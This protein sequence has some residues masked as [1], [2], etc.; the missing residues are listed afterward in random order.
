MKP[1]F[2]RAIAR[3]GALVLSTVGAGGAL[4]TT[5][6]HFSPEGEALR[7]NQVS[8]NFDAPVLALG[9]LTGPAPLTFRCDHGVK[10]TPRWVDT[11]TW[12]LDFSAALPAGIRCEFK[13]VAGFKDVA[14]KPVTM[15]KSYRFHTGGPWAVNVFAGYDS[16]RIDEEAVFLVQAAGDIDFS[17]VE[18]N[19]W[20]WADGIAEEIPVRLLGPSDKQALLKAR[21]ITGP[22]E[23]FH[24]AALRC[25]RRLPNGAKATLVWGEGI[26]GVSGLP[27]SQISR[28]EFQVREEFSVKVSCQRENASAGCHPF[29]DIALRFTAPVM[30]ED[31]E[32]IRLIGP[33]NKSWKPELLSYSESEGDENSEF[34][35]QVTFKG[36][37]PAEAAFKLKVPGRIRDDAGRP[38]ANRD[39]LANV[40]LATAL[41]PPLL[42]FAADFGIVEQKA[43]ALL[44]VTLRNLDPLPAEPGLQTA[45]ATPPGTAASLK[46]VRVTTDEE[47]F[48]WKTKLRKTNW[49]SDRSVASSLLGTEASAKTVLLPKPHGPKPMEVVGIPLK[50]PG[51]YYLEAESRVLGRSLL[52]KDASFLVRTEALSTNLAVHFKKGA[53]NQLVWVTTLDTAKPV[54]DARIAIRDC[55]GAQLAFGKTGSD[56]TMLVKRRLAPNPQRCEAGIYGYYVSARLTQ[57][58]VEDFSFTLSDWQRGIEP[59]RYQ[60]PYAGAI[61]DILTHTIFDR[62]LFRAGETV[63]MKHVARRHT[64]GGYAW[65]AR[66]QLPEKA[67]IQLEG[68]DTRYELPLSW[69]GGSAESTWQIPA[70]AKLGK[71]WVSFARSGESVGRV[72]AGGDEGEGESEGWWGPSRFWLGG[73]FRVGEFRLP[74]LKGEVSARLAVATGGQAEVDLKLA[75]LAGGAASGDK[76]R[77]RSELSPL[78]AMPRALP[79]RFEQYVFGSAPVD[80]EAMQ[81]GGWQREL[82][83]S[84]VFDDQRDLVLDTAGTK[85]VTVGNIPSWP[86]PGQ[87]RSEMEYVDPSG[88]VHTASTTTT[89]FPSGVL[90]GV[91]ADGNWADAA[92]GK[93]GA[94]GKVRVV[95]LDSSLQPKADVPFV[96]TA[97]QIKTLAHRKRL[98]GGLYSY[99]TQYLPVALGAL[100]KGQTDAQGMAECALT[101]PARE[102]GVE[103]MQVVLEVRAEDAQQK[104]AHASTALWTSAYGDEADWYEQ[105]DSERI[106]LVAERKKYEP[107]ETAHFTVQMPFREA[108][109]LVSVEREGILDRFVIPLSAKSPKISVPIKPN[110][111]PNVFISA[112]VVR[113]RVGDLQPTALVDLGKP[114]YKLGIAEIEVGRKGYE[115]KVAVE[116]AQPVYKTREQ[117]TV[118]VRVTKP[119]GS[120][121]KG[122]EFALAAVD[123]ALL[124]LAPN[125]SWDLLTRLLARRGYAVETSTAQSQVIGKRHFGLKALPAGG[126]GGRQPTREFFDTLIQWQARVVLDEKGEAVV[127]LPLNDSLTKIRVVA[128]AQHGAG[129]FGTGSAS[130]RTSK[131]VQIFSGLPPVV[132]DADRLRAAFTVRNLTGQGAEFV[133]S[134]VVSSRVNRM[135]AET[136]TP[137]AAL[138]PQTIQLGAGEGRE[139]AWPISVPAESS[140][141]LWRAEARVA[142]QAGDAAGA[143]DALKVQQKVLASVPVRVQAATLEHLSNS[144]Q[145]P[146]QR[147]ADALADRGSVDVFLKPTLGGSRDGVYDWMS[148][149]PHLCLEQQLSVA[150]ATG[151]LPR[152]EKVQS[153]VSSYLDNNGLASYFKNP[154]PN[155]GSVSLTAYILTMAH[156]SGYPVPES[157]RDTMLRGLASF[158]EGRV[159][160]DPR[161]W[162][163]REDLVQRKLKA[164]EALARYGRATPQHLATVAATP[165]LWPLSGVVSWLAV[166]QHVPN[167][168]NPA[169]RQAQI[170]EAESQIRARMVRSGTLTQFTG[171]REDYWWW[172]MDSPDGTA[173][174][175][176][177]ALMELPGW[178]REVPKLVRGVLSRQREGHWDTTTANAWGIVMLEQ[179]RRKY[180]SQAVTGATEVQLGAARQRFDWATLPQLQAQQDAAVAAAQA[181]VP[182]AGTQWRDRGTRLRF[183]WPTGGAGTVQA[184][185]VG[186]GTPW[187]TVQTRAARVLKAPQYAGFN[188]KKE[189]V[190]VDRKVKDRWSKG[191]V[192]EVRLTLTAPAPWTWVVVDDPVPTGA[193]ILGSGLGRESVLAA[194][195]AAADG[196]FGGNWWYEPVHTERAFDAYR[197]YYE[198]FRASEKYP[199][200]LRYRMRLNNAGEFVLPPTRVE[201]MYAPENFGELPNPAWVVAQ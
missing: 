129:L 189:I 184:S 174:R 16:R 47:V 82:P 93:A 98:V 25:A 57:N 40:E 116:P 94:P 89:W 21:G 197:A 146:V 149:Y 188:V 35:D 90:V 30:R 72:Y 172:L 136:V 142:A 7:L 126:G 10:G 91:Q 38:L 3:I 163:P 134:A 105:G 113:G 73:S 5:L 170:T 92:P 39:R 192:V 8:A 123:E 2:V 157:V 190:A 86:V 155:T 169:T 56:G 13:P 23:H 34:V 108:T 173:A 119:D 29:S 1:C 49:Y 6:A 183:D 70:E 133:V 96:V 103:S 53:E 141:L 61:P 52:D 81:Q 150:L 68:S 36:P 45:D 186:T 200:T 12:V 179:F 64:T 153:I 32:Q 143:S 51:Y 125:R 178:E 132:R 130:L 151:N 33:S 201:A 145:V 118:T 31:A 109:A 77:V 137:L 46:F 78:Y 101:L 15:A 62:P 180:E 42:K 66:E 158:V 41:H 58:G 4:A 139:V 79:A 63:H 27:T 135:G 11:Q 121:A 138:A 104:A 165:G 166:L 181:P 106:N 159:A 115:L 37:F 14:G 195:A 156:L 60:L 110:Y 26:K 194:S 168:P 140:Q 199:A 50:E 124:E 117:A 127:K 55:N 19:A 144:L 99:D 18:K 164:L 84:V 28:H 75:Y 22:I 20:C 111:G 128:V 65:V 182:Q 102:K 160:P 191:D 196:G 17:T 114:A 80:A 175:L 100:C 120:P 107:G 187:V 67:V 131:D 148:R 161:Y 54:A 74:I 69:R 43:G 97:W 71:Y 176:I 167:H 198:Y 87:L 154:K 177:T 95:T 76:V 112:L 193:T 88:E 48:A 152:W 122:G 44:P 9:N 171:E 83:Q 85:R 185:Q 59:W 147:P 162:A 24:Y